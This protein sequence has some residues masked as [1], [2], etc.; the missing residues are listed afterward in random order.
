MPHKPSLIQQ[1]EHLGAKHGHGAQK[2]QPALFAG[3]KQ[4]RQQHA[5]TRQPVRPAGQQA[6]QRIHRAFGRLHKAGLR[7]IL[8]Q[9]VQR[10]GR[11][12][13]RRVKA[14]AL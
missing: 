1:V 9:R 10:L 8:A 5:A 6:G 14:P 3:K 11:E 7:R 2:G 12:Y 13:L 4:P